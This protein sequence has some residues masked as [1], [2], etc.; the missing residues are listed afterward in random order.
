MES[1]SYFRLVVSRIQVG[2]VPGEG[3]KAW[4]GARGLVDR[5]L[6]HPPAGVRG[7]SLW[8]LPSSASLLKQATFYRAHRLMVVTGG[9]HNANLAFVQATHQCVVGVEPSW[10]ALP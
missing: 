7:A 1:L 4:L 2:V 6:R 3:A 9:T 8:S 10:A 5:I